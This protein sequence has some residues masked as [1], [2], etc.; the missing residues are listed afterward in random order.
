MK[1]SIVSVAEALFEFSSSVEICF[2]SLFVSLTALRLLDL[3]VVAG[4]EGFSSF[5]VCWLED[6][7]EGCSSDGAKVKRQEKWYFYGPD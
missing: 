6:E 1:V 7:D 5:V 3:D 2:V 4:D